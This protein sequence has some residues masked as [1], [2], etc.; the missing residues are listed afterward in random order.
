MKIR[1]IAG[2]D[3]RALR[4][5]TCGRSFYACCTS[6]AAFCRALRCVLQHIDRPKLAIFCEKRENFDESRRGFDVPHPPRASRSCA[7]VPT[8][9]QKACKACALTLRAFL[10]RCAQSWHQNR[11]VLQMKIARL[12]VKI[13][14][15]PR[16]CWHCR[17]CVASKNMWTIILCMLHKLDRKSVV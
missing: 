16:N 3:A 8:V 11:A 9:C 13:F 2:T 4:P 1:A 7:E 6:C 14:E 15:N 12:C 5:K 17:T 10:A